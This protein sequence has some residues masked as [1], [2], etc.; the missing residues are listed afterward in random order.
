MRTTAPAS[1]E[2]YVRSSFRPDREYVDGEIQERNLG[3]KDH[4]RVQKRLTGFFLRLEERTELRVWPEQRVQVRPANFRVPDICVTVGEPA[5]QIFTTPPYIIGEVLSPEDTVARL[6]ERIRD[7]ATFGVP[8]I[9]IIDPRA[10]CA[11]VA[12]KGALQPAEILRA[13]SGPEV[14]LNIAELFD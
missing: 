14:T 3:E 12:L 6:M 4:S 9:W 8:N 13:E 1:I 2:E 5:E 11:Y 7:Y 10:R